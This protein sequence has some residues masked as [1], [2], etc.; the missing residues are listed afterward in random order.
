MKGSG[1]GTNRTG[2]RAASQRAKEL[3]QATDSCQPTPPGDTFAVRSERLRWLKTSPPVGSPPQAGGRLRPLSPARR[4]HERVLLDVLGE[5]L[6][7]ARTFA[8]LQE[9]ARLHLEAH[10]PSAETPPLEGLEELRRQTLVHLD[11]VREAITQA[12]GDATQLTPSARVH[13]TAASGLLQVV[14][15]PRTSVRHV[16]EMLLIASLTDNA[17]WEVLVPLLRES[18]HREQAERFEEAHRTAAF[19]LA[20]LRGWLERNLG[21]E[22]GAELAE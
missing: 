12:G 13:A 16:L 3:R 4:A 22:V 18:G 11:V 2:V 17:G 20:T 14:A 6:G 15:D 7:Q 10:G 9:L 5:R 19:Q 8:R 1:P 21:G